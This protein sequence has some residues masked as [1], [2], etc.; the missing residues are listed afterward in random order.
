M[1]AYC[2]CGDLADFRVTAPGDTQPEILCGR[3][4]TMA[5]APHA[6]GHRVEEL[7]EDQET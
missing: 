2:T 4:A 1:P 6:P 3:C 5:L 7:Q